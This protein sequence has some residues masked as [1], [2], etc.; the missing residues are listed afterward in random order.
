MAEDQVCPTPEL[1]NELCAML[2]TPSTV[3][4]RE[5][6]AHWTD[7]LGAW[8]DDREERE[9]VA[10]A[11]RQKEEE[12]KKE[13]GVTAREEEGGE[14]HVAKTEA[15]EADE[16]AEEGEVVV[17]RQDAKFTSL[18]LRRPYAPAPS[19]VAGFEWA[20]ENT[21]PPSNSTAKRERKR[22][23]AL[24]NNRAGRRRLN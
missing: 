1:L 7:Q 9:R 3:R 12:E 23:P 13:K 5:A 16:K 10:T 21:P 24:R 4:S 18:M 15:A 8:L 11:E 14:E 2:R 6:L 22:S 20:Q 17:P 19:E